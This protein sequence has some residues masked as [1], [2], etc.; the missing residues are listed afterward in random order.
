RV[1]V[2]VAQDD[3]IAVVVQHLADVAQALAFRDAGRGR[4]GDRHDVTAQ[5]VPRGLERQP[6]ARGWL[7]EGADQD[8]PGEGPRGELRLG[9]EARGQPR[10]LHELLARELP[11]GQHR[12]F[13]EVEEGRQVLVAALDQRTGTVEAA[14][15]ERRILEQLGRD[16]ARP[17]HHSS[18][19]FRSRTSSARSRSGAATVTARA[20]ETSTASPLAEM[21][22]RYLR[23]RRDVLRGAQPSR[24]GSARAAW[25]RARPPWTPPRR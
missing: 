4:V 13:H 15:V 25:R 16:G 7:V 12:A 1:R 17:A 19:R 23:M 9:L 5:A 10:E 3:E 11:G 6:R 8:L 20:T 24:N 21:I 22:M 18:P 14:Q 2:A